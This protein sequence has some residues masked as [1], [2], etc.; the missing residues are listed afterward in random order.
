MFGLVDA[1][2]F[3]ARAEKVFDPSI[4]HKPVVVLTNNDGCICAVC[5]LAK[6]LGVPKF[7]PYFKIKSFLAKHNVVVRSSNYELYA[8][9]SERMMNVI[10]RYSNNHYVYS[11]DESFLHFKNFS[12]IDDWHQYGHTIRKAIWRET[13]LPVGVGFGATLTLAKAANHASKKLAGFDGVAVIDDNDS[14][15]EI[16]SRMS[17][18]DVWGIGTKLGKRLNILGLKNGWDLANQSPKAMRGQFGVTVERTVNELNAMPCLKWDEIGQDKQEIFST[19]SF[20]QRV[21][22]EHALKA[23]LSSH[24]SIVATKVRKQSA[25]IKRLVIFASSSPHD[26]NYYKKSVIYEF[27]TATDN[28]LKLVGA[29]SS[30]FDNIYR[31]GV[32]FYRC[33]VGGIDLES[34]QFL[35]QD[36]FTQSVNNPVLMKC[37][38]QINHRYGRG[39]VEVAIAEK[40]KKW[41]M[42]RSFLS[43]RSTS[44]W[45]EIPKIIC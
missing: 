20:G 7:I 25:L 24:A 30:V 42:R 22:D 5:P 17:I 29:I 1:V 16:L 37:Y 26:N 10:A 43:P 9:L 27:P 21:T 11:I 2:S 35:Q 23:A 8:D 38:D 19:R 13:R 44:N 14:R 32:S 3:Y 39:T 33:G 6:A 28:T 12:C 45:S 18:T 15:K 41:A 34:S 36:M 4:R 40:N 31:Q